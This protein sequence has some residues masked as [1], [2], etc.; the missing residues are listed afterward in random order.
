MVWCETLQGKKAPSFCEGLHACACGCLA[1]ANGRV[2]PTATILTPTT[3]GS[4]ETAWE[5]LACCFPCSTW[6][7]GGCRAP[8]CAGEVC[9]SQGLTFFPGFMGLHS[10]QRPSLPVWHHKQCLASGPS[11]WMVFAEF[12]LPRPCL[13]RYEDGPLSIFWSSGVYQR[14]GENTDH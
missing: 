12:S 3:G 10:S 8:V 13:L 5:G 14:Q 7:P 4:R 2:I 11:R 6:L 9:F 1:R